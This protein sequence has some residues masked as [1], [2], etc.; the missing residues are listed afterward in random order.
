[1]NEI[2]FFFSMGGA[3]Q[4]SFSFFFFWFCKFFFCRNGL[5]PRILLLCVNCGGT[6]FFSGHPKHTKVAH[7]HTENK[8]P[9]EI[10]EQELQI[11]E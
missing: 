3:N 11:L 10:V 4:N 8:Q 1:M 2:I 6:Q 9:F 5:A 7:S